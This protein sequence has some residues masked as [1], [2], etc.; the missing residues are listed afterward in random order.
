MK[1]YEP[2]RH[3]RQVERLREEKSN[4]EST[5]GVGQYLS[6]FLLADLRRFG[7]AAS[8]RPA[9]AEP[10]RIVP[11]TP[12]RSGLRVFWSAPC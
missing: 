2:E 7:D 12:A 6:Q 1:G 11:Q 9:C 8:Q 3:Y 4:K 10:G 5:L